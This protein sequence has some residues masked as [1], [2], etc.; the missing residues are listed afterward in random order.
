M[1]TFT[2]LDSGFIAQNPARDDAAYY[3]AVGPRVVALPNGDVV[4]S[5]MRTRQ[6]ATNDFVPCLARSTDGGKSWDATGPIWPETI[7]RLSIFAS[8]SRDTAGQLFVYGSRTPIETIGE[9]FWSDATQ[10]LKQNELFWSSSPDGGRSW[11][12]Q[13]PIAMQIAGSA[14]APGPLCVTNDGA[15]LAPY[16][17]YNTVDAA[18]KVDLGQVVALRSH[19]RGETWS[20]RS[21]I[22][23]AEPQSGGAEAWVIELADGR[24]LATAWHLNLSGGPDHPNKFA[25]SSDGGKSWT[26]ARSTGILGQSTALTALPD[27]RALFIYNQRKHGEAGVWIAVARPTEA[28]FGVEANEIV[29]RA[30]QPTQH[31]TAGDHAQWSDFSFGEPSATI[32]PD[33]TVLVAL[34]C[35]QPGGSG[36][37]YVR[38]KLA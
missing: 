25:L 4:C 2:T 36:V 32:L 37:A 17:P 35:L 24:L 16:S 5:Y 30:A 3:M 13:Q 12:G 38:L 15:W 6:T 1:S 29:W 9:A 7:D 19:D 21:M 8:I 18:V 20:S 28:D 14:E 10:G 31:G 27:G 34:W 23:F 33:G 26:P 22:R 11:S